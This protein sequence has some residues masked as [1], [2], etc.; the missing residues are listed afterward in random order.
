MS[1][2]ID[3]NDGWQARA[4]FDL[5]M[6]PTFPILAITIEPVEGRPIPEGGISRELLERV[7]LN[8]LREDFVARLALMAVVR[9]ATPRGDETEQEARERA[10]RRVPTEKE[11]RAFV[12]RMRPSRKQALSPEDELADVALR[13]LDAQADDPQKVLNSMQR[14]YWDEGRT[15]LTYYWIRNKVRECRTDGRWLTAPGQ[16]KKGGTQ[17]GPA[18]LEWISRNR[19]AQKEES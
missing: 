17:P 7:H 11:L 18:L 15:D 6:A 9:E 12:R 4:T 14:R 16:G 5:A 10:A 8:D 19:P 2:V 1:A 3:L 13:Y